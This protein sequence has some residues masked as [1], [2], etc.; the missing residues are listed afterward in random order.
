[1]HAIHVYMFTY[2]VYMV[3]YTYIRR[4]CIDGT[5][6]VYMSSVY[7]VCGLHVMCITSV[8]LYG[9]YSEYV[10]LCAHSCPR[11]HQLLPG[12]RTAGQ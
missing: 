11:S 12:S 1:M 10:L 5:Y 9:V 4:G 7:I 3:L 8:Y 6:V 2:S